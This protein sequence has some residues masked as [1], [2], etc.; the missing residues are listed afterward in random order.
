MMIAR[1]FLPGKWLSTMLMPGILWTRTLQRKIWVLI[2]SL[3]L[4][5]SHLATAEVARHRLTSEAIAVE[6]TPDI[7]GRLLSAN[8]VGQPNILLVGDAVTAMPDPPVSPESVNIGY[9]GHEVWVGPQSEWWVHQSLNQARR[10]ARAVWPPDPYLVLA[11]NKLVEK[12]A[13]QITLQGSESPISGVAMQKQ[14]ALVEGKS[15]Q[16]ELTVSAQNIRDTQVAWD[17]WFNTRVPHTS[18]VYVP[19]KSLDD[20]RIEHL[21]DAAYGPL[22]QDYHEGIFSLKNHASGQKGRKGKVFIQP[23]QGWLAAFRDQQ[24]LIIAFDLQPKNRIHPEQGQ[25]ELYQEFLNDRPAQ[26]LLELE[27]HAA[28]KPLKPQEIMSASELW[29]LLPYTGAHT[30]QAHHEFLRKLMDAGELK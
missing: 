8:L 19:V 18:F 7:G 22:A 5:A 16:L 27:V 1:P 6:I 26:G 13:R 21:T 20:V 29:T 25:V 12:S 23:S 2:M 28:Y 11:K 24:V 9:L 3:A 10:E 4:F 15:N 14:F 17:I 30:Q